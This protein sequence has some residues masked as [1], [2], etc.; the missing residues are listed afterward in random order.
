MSASPFDDVETVHDWLP[1]KKANVRD[2][3]EILHF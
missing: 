3:I 1:A 2:E